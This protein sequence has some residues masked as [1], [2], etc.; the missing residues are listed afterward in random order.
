VTGKLKSFRVTVVESKNK[1]VKEVFMMYE[2]DFTRFMR[3]LMD[4]HPELTELQKRNRATWWDKKLDSNQQKR[5][6]ESRAP[7]NGYVYFP[8]PEAHKLDGSPTTS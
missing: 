7:V 6:D 5:F 3:E 8:M 4:K 1:Y 2:S